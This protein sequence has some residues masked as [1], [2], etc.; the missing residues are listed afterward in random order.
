[1]QIFE[2]NHIFAYIFRPSIY[3]SATYIHTIFSQKSIF[4]AENK[5]YNAMKK[6]KRHRDYGFWDQHIR[7]FRAVREGEVQL[8]NA[9]FREAIIDYFF[10]SFVKKR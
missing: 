4:V 2:I 9:T 10:R 8:V 3:L 6:F 1:M 7:T 5:R